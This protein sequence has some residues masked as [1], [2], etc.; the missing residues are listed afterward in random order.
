M[1]RRLGEDIGSSLVLDKYAKW[2]SLDVLSFVFFTD[3]TNKFFSNEN[4]LK[5]FSSCIIFKLLNNSKTI[6]KY[7][8]KEA[9]GL[10]G[11]IPKLLKGE[12]I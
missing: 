6:K 5:K 12:K 8:M 3:F 4:Y 7:L 11:D 9:S 1:S 10:S 2:R